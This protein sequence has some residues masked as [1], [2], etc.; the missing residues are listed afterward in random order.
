MDDA[1]VEEL[2]RRV[3]VILEDGERT[4]PPEPI[5]EDA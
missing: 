1:R 3:E 2:E 5:E 4:G